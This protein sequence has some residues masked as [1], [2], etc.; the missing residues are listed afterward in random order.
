[1]LIDLHFKDS[2]RKV[3]GNSSNLDNLLFDR[4]QTSLEMVFAS[5]NEELRQ[6]LADGN[7]FV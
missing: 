5:F 7:S 6:I 1:M 2:P 3:F 4:R